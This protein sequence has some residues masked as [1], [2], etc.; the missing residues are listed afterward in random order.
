MTVDP[1]SSGGGT[2]IFPLDGPMPSPVLDKVHTDIPAASQADIRPPCY[3]RPTAAEHD[4]RR[5]FIPPRI[6][7]SLKSTMLRCVAGCSLT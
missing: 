3:E 7:R 2:A 1:H 6:R 5:I 4:C